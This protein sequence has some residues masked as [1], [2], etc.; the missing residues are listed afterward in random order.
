M[1][2]IKEDYKNRGLLRHG[3]HLW[4]L[5]KVNY[6]LLFSVLFNNLGSWE[7]YRPSIKFQGSRGT[8]IQH[9]RNCLL[10]CVKARHSFCL[11]QLHNHW[12]QRRL[13]CK[14]AT[15]S[16]SK[17]RNVIE[18]WAIFRSVLDK[19]MWTFGDFYNFS[20]PWNFLKFVIIMPRAAQ[21]ISRGWSL[22]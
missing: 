17:G 12:H 6:L 15:R 2:K 11:S 22:R 1:I 3:C 8:K 19:L 21:Y 10:S 13:R 7:R 18:L 16:N 5:P 14:L 4:D 20:Q 9:V